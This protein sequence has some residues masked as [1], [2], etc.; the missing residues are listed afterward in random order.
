MDERQMTLTILITE[1][2]DDYRGKWSACLYGSKDMDEADNLIFTA[3]TGYGDT[4]LEATADLLAMAVRF[5][6]A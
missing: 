5:A 2:N 1:S 6:A 3:I 4:P